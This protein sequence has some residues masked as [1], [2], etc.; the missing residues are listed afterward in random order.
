MTRIFPAV[1]ALVCPAMG[2]LAQPVLYPS[3]TIR[4]IVPAP[5]RTPLDHAARIV[6]RGLSE[7]WGEAVVAD[8]RAA[9]SGVA[10][11]ELVASAQPDGHTLLVQSNAFVTLPLFYKLPHD[12]ERDFIPL[13]RIATSALALVVHPPLAAASVKELIA[14]AR[15]KSGALAYASPGDGSNPHLAGEMLRGVAGI[16]ISHAA[17]REE[18]DALG[19]VMAGRAQ[20]MFI[21][22]VYALPHVTSGT[23]RALATTGRARSPLL[24][25]LPTLAESGVAGYEYGL[26]AA[27][28]VAAGTPLPVVEKITAELARILESPGTEARLLA[29]GYETAWLPGAEFQRFLR[30]ESQRFAAWAKKSSLKKN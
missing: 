2:A 12:T 28:F 4:L 6:G 19:E 17:R 9:G 8:N 1:L 23:L 13:A 30:G 3:K 29:Q 11:Q 15:Q 14:L 27:V 26:W 21:D 22:V 5:A 18:P 16:N 25:T 7:A 20:L 24:P 10:G